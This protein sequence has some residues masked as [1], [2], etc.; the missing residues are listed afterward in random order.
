VGI[1]RQVAP[2]ARA[3]VNSFGDGE[4][5]SKRLAPNRIP[6]LHYTAYEELAVLWNVKHFW[7]T[8]AW[9]VRM[10][11]RGYRAFRSGYEV[12][13]AL[14]LQEWIHWTVSPTK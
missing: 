7:L 2:V 1:P 14:K 10:H 5:S 13:K 9:E 6:L 4:A 8:H 3:V 11:W 12:L